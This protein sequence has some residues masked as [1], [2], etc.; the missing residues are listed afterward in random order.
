MSVKKPWYKTT[1]ILYLINFVC[2]LVCDIEYNLKACWTTSLFLLLAVHGILDGSWVYFLEVW[3]LSKSFPSEK[4]DKLGPTESRQGRSEEFY[5]LFLDNDQLSLWTISVRLWFKFWFNA[6]VDCMSMS[7][8]PS[9]IL[10]V[11]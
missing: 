4:W 9:E 6:M 3:C 10:L 1:G 11:P 8:F 5:I 2:H 7:N